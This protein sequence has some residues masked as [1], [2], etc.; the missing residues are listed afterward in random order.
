[1]TDYIAVPARNADPTALRELLAGGSPLRSQIFAFLLASLAVP[2]LTG[3]VGK[4]AEKTVA[5]SILTYN[6]SDIGYDNVFVN[7]EMAP[8]GYPIGP[9]GKFSGGGKT[10]CCIV[11]PAKW[12]PGLKA[13][14]YW[15][16]YRMEDDLRWTPPAQMA[17]VEIP[18]YKPDPE[19]GTIGRFF[20]HFYPNHQVRAMVS[21]VDPGYPDTPGSPDPDLAPAATGR[22]VPPASE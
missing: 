16:Y 6:H 4:S 18:E 22:P 2:G 12:R 5:L 11:L 17:D 1:M 7:G 9:G 21:V 15:E 13:R 20:I 8:W 10:T 14:I 3:C 19:T